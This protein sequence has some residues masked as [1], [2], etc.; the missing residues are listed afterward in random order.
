MHS[1]KLVGEGRWGV[2]F[3]WIQRCKDTCYVIEYEIML[4]V[5]WRGG[6]KDISTALKIC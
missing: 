2:M 4:R 3:D 5:K 6:K 1:S